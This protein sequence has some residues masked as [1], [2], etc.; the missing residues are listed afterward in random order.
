MFYRVHIDTIL[1]HAGCSRQLCR[2]HNS[3]R[4]NNFSIA[5][6]HRYTPACGVVVVVVA[7][8]R[9]TA[10]NPLYNRVQAHSNTNVPLTVRGAQSRLELN[11][12][13]AH[14]E[15]RQ[16]NVTATEVVQHSAQGRRRLLGQRRQMDSP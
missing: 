7:S 13:T 5:Q 9:T 1:Q 6:F 4:C 15:R 8:A 12:Y 2:N 11:C 10:R 3:R 16:R 14:T